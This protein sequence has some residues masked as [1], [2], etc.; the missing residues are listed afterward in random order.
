MADKGKVLSKYAYSL[1]FLFVPIEF[2]IQ[3]LPLNFHF[4][5]VLANWLFTIIQAF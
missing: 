3:F 5:T 1:I 4:S 2:A